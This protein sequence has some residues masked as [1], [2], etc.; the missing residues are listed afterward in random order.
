L[1]TNSPDQ[2][3][4]GRRHKLRGFIIAE[5]IAIVVLLAAG[6]LVVSTRPVDSMVVTILNVVMFLAA[7]S[8]AAIPILCFAFAPILLRSNR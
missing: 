8:A 6:T 4:G 3:R 2:N 5:T 1:D 7:A